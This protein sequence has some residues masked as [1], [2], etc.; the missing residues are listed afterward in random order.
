MG[1]VGNS[2]ERISKGLQ[3]LGHQVYLVVL[4]SSRWITTPEFADSYHDNGVKVFHIGPYAESQFP[5]ENMK[6][7]AEGAME[8][9]KGLLRRRT[10]DQIIRI[11]TEHPVD[12]LISFDLISP[13]I[14]PVFIGRYFNIPVISGI[15]GS[16]V[17]LSLFRNDTFSI[18]Q[19]VVDG[20]QA[21]ASVNAY[22]LERMLLMFP[23][24]K[25]KSSVIR[26]GFSLPDIPL[27]RPESRK[28]ILEA[29]RWN[30]SDLILVFSGVMREA[31]GLLTIMKLLG[32]IASENIRLLVVGPDLTGSA[33][34]AMG[35][36][37]EAFKSSG[38]LHV[39]GQLVH[40]EVFQWVIGGDII[41]FPSA[42]EGIANGLLEGM[43]LGLC[44]VVSDVL[45]EVVTHEEDG[46]VVPANDPV[47]LRDALLYL[48]RS[49]GI[50]P[51]LGQK[52]KETVEEK[53][54]PKVE[55]NAYLS[56]IRQLVG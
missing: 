20:V 17:A 34:I 53:F 4:D 11:F 50:L 35:K 14:I 38:Q 43:A 52:A 30:D 33:A 23:G 54:N 25:E 39:T 29:A 16:D 27:S 44:P 31:K 3:S 56:L 2:A 55:L 51:Q 47:R 40:E 12:C 42:S 32:M 26:N 7:I 19:T 37:W 1:G 36:H 21:I 5:Q 18:F 28:R 15:R 49:R 9:L 46:W 22:L 10:A 48:N 45:A 13:G 24:A 8:K 6:A 41:F